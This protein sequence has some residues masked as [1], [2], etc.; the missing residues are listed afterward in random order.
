[1]GFIDVKQQTV[2][3]RLDRLEEEGRVSS[4]KISRG[5]VWWIPEDKNDVENDKE[6]SSIYWRDIDPEEIPTSMI[7]AHPDYPDPDQWEKLRIRGQNMAQDAAIPAIV[8]F[9]ILLFRSVE[10]PFISIG[11]NIYTVGA[12]LF[13]GGGLFV[14]LGFVISLFSYLKRRIEERGMQLELGS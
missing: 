10:L 6:S 2:K 14:L 9:A 7:E 12:I 1:M 3:R 4:L 8:G 5:H 13:I 11:Q